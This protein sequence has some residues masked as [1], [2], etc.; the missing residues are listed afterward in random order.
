MQR[1]EAVDV[2]ASTQPGERPEGIIGAHGVVDRRRRR[3]GVGVG[4]AARDEQAERRDVVHALD[5]A[6]TRPR[7]RACR[8]AAK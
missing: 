4:V 1:R 6:D 3:V 2:V 8:K 5:V 7:P